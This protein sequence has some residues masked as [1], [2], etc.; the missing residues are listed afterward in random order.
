MLVYHLSSLEL[1]E[2]PGVV[3]LLQLNGVV[4]LLV[5]VLR[6]L[7]VCGVCLCSLALEPGLPLWHEVEVT[8]HEGDPTLVVDHHCLDVPDELLLGVQLGL[9]L[10]VDV[11]DLQ[12]HVAEVDIEGTAATRQNIDK[13]MSICSFKKWHDEQV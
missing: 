2:Q 12:G 8:T 5:E 1:D 13:G 6:D 11:D 10:S 7:V 9:G 3:V 4:E